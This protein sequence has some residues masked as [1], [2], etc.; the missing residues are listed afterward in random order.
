MTMMEFPTAEAK[1]LIAMALKEDI[2]NGDIT[3]Q[4]TFKNNE[5]IAAK[6]ISKDKGILAGLPFVQ[7]VFDQFDAE[8]SISFHQ[9]E[10]DELEKGD[11]IFSVEGP[12]KTVLEA[13]RTILNFMQLL[14]GVASYTFDFVKETQGTETKILD[15]RKTIPG[16]RLLQ[17]YAVSVGRGVNHRIGLYDMVMLKENH[18]FAAGG[19]V[20]ALKTVFSDLPKGMKVEVEVENLAQLKTCL[21]FPV[22]RV[23]LDNMN[24]ELL[25]EAVAIVKEANHTMQTEASGNMTLDRIQSVSQTGVDYISVGAITHSVMAFDFS[26][27]YQ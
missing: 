24:N 6:V 7:L 25:T 11:P 1:S 13:E 5:K 12:A 21:D 2:S 23:L 4:L 27:R 19:L 10:G 14:S 18:I 8:V 20:P 26:M 17:K 9:E 15:T 22:Y 3:T 16:F